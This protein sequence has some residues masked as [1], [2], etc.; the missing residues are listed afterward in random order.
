MKT[1]VNIVAVLLTVILSTWPDETSAQIPIANMVWIPAGAFTMGDT[2]NEGSSIERPTHTV[3][4]SGLYMDKYEVTKALLDEVKAW[5]GGNGYSYDYDG[6]AKATNHPIH[7]LNWYDMVKWCNARSQ[8]EELTPCYYINAGLSV[9]YKTGQVDPFVKW[10]ANGYRLPTEAEWEKAARGGAGGHR[11]SWSDAN[12]ITH[13][14]AN[15]YSS[16]SYAYDIS[17]TRGYHPTFA[18]GTQP[19]TSTVGYFAPNGY[20]LYDMTGNVAEWCWDWHS[21]SYYSVSPATDPRGPASGQFRVVRGRR[22]SDDAY[23]NRCTYRGGLLLNAIPSYPYDGFGFRSVLQFYVPEG[24]RQAIEA[25]PAQPVYGICPV[26]EPGKDNLILV[27]HGWNLKLLPTGSPPNPTWIDSLSNSISSY[28]TNQGLNNWQ[29]YGYKWVTNSWKLNPDDALEKAGEEGVKLGNCISTQGWGHIHLIAHSAGSRL[30]QAASEIVKSNSPSTTVHTTFLDPYVGFNETGITNYGKGANWSDSYF[31]RDLLT[32]GES[33]PLTQGS[34]DWCHNVDVTWL[35][36]N[37]PQVDGYISTSGGVGEPCRVTKTTH[38]WPVNFYANTITGNVTPDYGGFGFPLSKE[39]GNW[40]YALANYSKGNTPLRVLG[41]ADPPCAEYLYQSTPAT[42][43]PTVNFLG[44]P[45]AGMSD[46]GYVQ[47]YQNAL[48][49]FPGSPVWLA[50]V[51]SLTNSVNFVSFDA[52]F[53]STNSGSRGLLSVFWDANVIGSVDEG[54]VQP[55]LQHYTFAFA[56]ANASHV[57]GFRLDPF[58]NALSSVIATNVTLGQSG[59][60][61]PFTL[62]FA[63]E[64]NGLRVLQ[65]TGQQGFTYTVEASTNLVN[66]NAIAVLANTN[67]TVRFIDQS[68]TNAPARFYRAVAP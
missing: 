50:T 23:Y 28:L 58:T 30:I 65:L 12:T 7:S 27:T 56:G 60:S 40:N 38:G 22:C 1:N 36:P 15:Y 14:R 2:F 25:Q 41:T 47:K 42:I 61:Q 64:T 33:W 48:Q 67:G 6:S 37:K 34:L 29:I 46:T 17:P 9:I 11:F 49:L 57:L 20:G 24:W 4:V 21:I 44:N 59:A 31:S 62:S 55:G 39:G 45:T 43:G 51:I 53:V 26:K 68:A 32:G 66:W 35:D 3:Y 13:S 54:A 63:G 16:S 19:Y 18:V 52:R 5:N 10:D 8:K